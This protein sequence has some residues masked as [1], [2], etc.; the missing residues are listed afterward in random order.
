[1]TSTR[2]LGTPLA[3]R[4]N[5]E[6]VLPVLVV[7]RG[8]G[9]DLRQLARV[10]P[11]SACTPPTSRTASTA[12]SGL[13]QNWRGFL[14]IQL[15][16]VILRQSRGPRVSVRDADFRLKVVQLLDRNWQ[17]HGRHDLC[18]GLAVTHDMLCSCP[19]RTTVRC[20]FADRVQGS[21]FRLCVGKRRG[22]RVISW[23]D[24]EVRRR[25]RGGRAGR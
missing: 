2:Q 14:R 10:V 6:R 22:S 16:E 19:V 24:L 7:E 21:G 23:R 18:A 11:S 25:R 1:M 12:S 15:S 4:A 17:E 5:D 13:P 8:R 9:V 20:W 3:C